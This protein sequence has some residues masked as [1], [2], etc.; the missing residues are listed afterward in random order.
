MM[1]P[2]AGGAAPRRLGLGGGGGLAGHYGLRS[3]LVRLAFVL[4]ALAGGAGLALYVVLA[5]LLPAHVYEDATPDAHGSDP[6]GVG[7]SDE[8]WQ[9]RIGSHGDDR[10]RRNTV[11]FV[12]MVGGATFLLFNFGAFGWFRWGTWWPVVFIGAGLALVAVRFRR[13]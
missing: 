11:A 13:A 10:H 4:L 2:G 3:A 5:T 12:M 9:Y 6:R 1:P 7:R 8:P